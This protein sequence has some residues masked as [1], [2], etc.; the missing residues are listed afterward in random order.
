M[1]ALDSTDNEVVSTIPAIENALRLQLEREGRIQSAEQDEERYL[2][3]F[4]ARAQVFF[5][6]KNYSAAHDL[7]DLIFDIS[8]DNAQAMHLKDRIDQAVSQEL[9][10]HFD[11]ARVAESEGRIV[12]AIESYNRILE[13]DP[14]NSEAATARQKALENLDWPQQ[15]NLGISLY[16]DNRLAEARNQFNAVL[17][18]K[19]GE[20]VA[21]EYLKKL[22]APPP[23]RRVAT[24]EDIQRDPQNWQHYL[25][26]LRFMR[27]GEY[28]KAIDEWEKVLQVYHDNPNTLNNIEQARLRLGTE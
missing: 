19:P 10:A 17:R 22:D 6:H 4:Y 14:G 21:L 5:D 24:L 18:L 11:T 20:S 1:S 27:N 12:R 3:N 23:R 9:S 7:L 8:P 25:D 15:L 13:L 16:E 28:Q 26:G 2:R